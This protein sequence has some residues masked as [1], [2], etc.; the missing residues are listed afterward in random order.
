VKNAPFMNPVLQSIL[1]DGLFK[2]RAGL[3]KLFPEEFRV[4]SG[5]REVPVVLIALAAT[6]VNYVS[7]QC[8]SGLILLPRVT[9][10]S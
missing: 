5:E 1:H 6:Y 3:Y 9:Y 7:A 2:G 10:G 4:Q 8:T